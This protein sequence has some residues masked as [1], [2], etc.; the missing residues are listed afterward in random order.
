MDLTVLNLALPALSAD[1]R[2]SSAE[3]LW[4]VDVYGFMVAGLLITMGSLGDRIGR[5]RLLLIGAAG[6]GAASVLAAFSTSAGMLIAARALLGVAGAT[7]APSTLSLIRT[8]FERPRERT[9]A[10]GIWATAFALGA[11]L[12]PLVGG[13]LLERFWWGSVFLVAVPVMLV[14]LALGPLL[15]PEYCDPSARPLD[16]VSAALSLLAVL[17]AIGGVK[18]LAT[19]GALPLA[20]LSIALALAAAAAFVRRQGRLSHPLVD[21][22]LLRI[23]AFA[24]AL[25]ATTLATFLSFGAFLFV[26]QYLQ[27]VLE[28]PPLHAGLLTLPSTLALIAGSLLAPALVRRVP[29]PHLISL[30]FAL[31]AI[32]FALLTQVEG[33]QGPA[34]LVAG[35]VLFAFGVAP[36]GTLASDLVV[37]AAPPERAGSASALSQTAGELGGALGIAVLGSL[38]AAA[39]R[40]GMAPAVLDGVPAPA[41]ASCRDTLA[42]ASSVASQCSPASAA[43]LL[44]TARSAF[45]D[46]LH[47]GAATSAA[48]AVAMSAFVA[49]R[50][51]HVRHHVPALAPDAEVLAPHPEPAVET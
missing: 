44:H 25:V 38:G 45:L 20:A 8:M 48:L 18:R 33:A 14:V 41:H 29:P 36:V 51:R 40:A 28:L 4:I 9:L 7:V 11:A 6:F 34:F 10:I 22:R 15:L 43:S 32:G 26:A 2:P 37:T 46:S 13:V 42:A 23:P 12:G 47:L 39:Y 21:L 49:L 24:V 30:G 17:L 5:R 50:L 31:A 16:L 3:Q 1:L 35:T 19:S 27:L